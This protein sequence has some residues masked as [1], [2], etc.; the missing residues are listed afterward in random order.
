MIYPFLRAETLALCMRSLTV[1]VVHASSV[2]QL[3]LGAPCIPCKYWCTY[4]LETKH[5]LFEWA[6][7]SYCWMSLLISD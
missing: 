5:L 6:F 1:H 7:P 2:Y 3:L 4:E